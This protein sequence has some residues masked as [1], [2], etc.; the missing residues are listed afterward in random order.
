MSED[1]TG[2]G[3]DKFMLRLPDGM[4]DRI[5][6]AAKLNKRS[7]NAEIVD[8]LENSFAQ[9]KSSEARHWQH[10]VPPNQRN[11]HRPQ[12]YAPELRYLRETRFIDLLQLTRTYAGALHLAETAIAELIRSLAEVDLLIEH[13][14]TNGRTFKA[15]LRF[16]LGLVSKKAA[17]D[18]GIA[19]TADENSALDKIGGDFSKVDAAILAYLHQ[20]YLVLPAGLEIPRH[21]KVD[22][23]SDTLMPQAQALDLGD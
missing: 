9:K 13:R 15:F 18:N 14:E 20:Q 6:D 1:G 8:R 21:P 2:R 4:R 7:M 22:S 10:P 12:V 3:S 23:A 5:G 16:A 11:I 17:K 19:V